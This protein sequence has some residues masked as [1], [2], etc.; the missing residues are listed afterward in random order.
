MSIEKHN[1]ELSSY[2]KEELAE[3]PLDELQRLRNKRWAWQK[4]EL[5]I[6]VEE[7]LAKRSPMKNWHCL[8]C[9]KNKYH[10]K[11]ARVAASLAASWM[12]LET[13]KY[14]VVICN[15]CGKSEFY[16][17]LRNGSLAIDFLT[18]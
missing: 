8:R 3:L 4:P 6:E 18:G 16:S 13:S 9:G 14:H 11:Q 10:T 1:K 17:V 5:V 2:T 7:E 15:Y 12:G